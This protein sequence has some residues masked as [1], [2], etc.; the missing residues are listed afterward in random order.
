MFRVQGL[1]FS[2]FR[3]RGSRAFGV[4]LGAEGFTVPRGPL[5]EGVQGMRAVR[6]RAIKPRGKHITTIITAHEPPRYS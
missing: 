3:L 5:V 4:S 1:G 6:F 2:G